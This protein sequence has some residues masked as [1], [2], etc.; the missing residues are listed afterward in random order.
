MSSHLT[1]GIPFTL[2][3]NTYVKVQAHMEEDTTVWFDVRA[4]SHIDVYLVDQEQFERFV[5]G[6]HWKYEEGESQCSIY[7]ETIEIPY[8]DDW[9]LLINNRSDE[10]IP[11]YF[12]LK[13]W[14][15][16]KWLSWLF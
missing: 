2:D 3:A 8:S 7:Q 6:D 10:N 5:N 1:P 13:I 15:S 9:T 11:T 14:T 16:P 4:G 12:D